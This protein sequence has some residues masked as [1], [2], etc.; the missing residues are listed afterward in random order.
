MSRRHRLGL[1]PV[2]EALRPLFEDGDALAGGS[3]GR[4]LWHHGPGLP[5]GVKVTGVIP[6]DFKGV[7]LTVGLDLVLPLGLFSQCF[8][9]LFF[10][11]FAVVASVCHDSLMALD[12]Q[13]SSSSWWWWSLWR[14]LS[15]WYIVTV[16]LAILV[17][18]QWLRGFCRSRVVAFPKPAVVMVSGWPCVA[19]ACCLGRRSFLPQTCFV[20]GS[21]EG[22]DTIVL[23]VQI[24]A[25]LVVC[26]PALTS[27]KADNTGLH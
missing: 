26:L 4:S 8:S 25:D 17:L 9:L 20:C 2:S 19:V 27:S 23:V 6:A 15:T 11:Y 12:F 16:T 24:L 10:V 22:E 5:C 13:T 1:R 3:L 7:A 21:S 18:V 14:W